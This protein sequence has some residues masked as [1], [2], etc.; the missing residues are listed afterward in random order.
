MKHVSV[1]DRYYTLSIHNDMRDPAATDAT[2]L[3]S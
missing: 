3:S 2:M 1:A